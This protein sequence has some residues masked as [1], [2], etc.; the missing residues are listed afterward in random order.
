MTGARTLRDLVEQAAGRHGNASGRQLAQ[1]AQ[2]AGY[3]V[4]HATLN[5]I[6]RGAYPSAPSPGTIRAIAFLAGVSEETAFAAAGDDA[7]EGG[8]RGA[9]RAFNQWAQLQM[10]ARMLVFRYAQ[11]REIPI[12]TA[13]EELREVLV[14]SEQVREGRPWTPPWDPG[15]GY[16]DKDTPWIEEWWSQEAVEVDAGETLGPE[17]A[18]SKIWRI[19]VP[20]WMRSREESE[21]S[22][23][24]V[25]RRASIKPLT[26]EKYI[27]EVQAQADRMDSPGGE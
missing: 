19:G 25:E 4:S 1:I 2:K 3:D 7:A 21:L 18:G 6:R 27:A 23:S 14:M 9:E 20:S 26:Q 17:L 22:P 8:D 5:R 13:E 12:A 24:R 10:Q 11:A 16:S 15:E